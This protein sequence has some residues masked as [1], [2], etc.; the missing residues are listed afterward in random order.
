MNNLKKVGIVVP[1]YRDFLD[2]FEKKSLKSI[3]QHF[4]DFE[5]IFAAPKGLSTSR[6]SSYFNKIKH[7]RI[8]YFS[9][10]CFDSIDAYNQLL[11][12]KEFYQTFEEFEYI[13]ICQLDVYVFK[14][15]LNE[16]CE[17][18]YDYVG[19]PWVGSERNFINVTFEKI[20]G[21]VRKLKGKNPKNTERLFKVGN[22]GFSLRK[23]EKFIQI[24]DEQSKQIE[25]FLTEKPESDYHIE[26]VFWSLFV[27]KKYTDYK[28]PN[29]KE[30]LDFC[31]DR[32]PEKSFKLN[33]NALPMACHRFNQ[34]KPYKFWRNYIK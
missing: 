20:N 23:V 27:P 19:A 2:E 22:G 34:P 29:W 7:L 14:N 15:K 33:N 12:S 1:I 30:A 8:E 16:W 25:L 11:L 10:N 26:D 9:S 24:S 32:K 6:Y 18:D 5:I 4:N 13:L 3:T 31:M 17:K 21:F 28:I